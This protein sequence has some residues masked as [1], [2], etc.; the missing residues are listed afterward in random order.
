MPAALAALVLASAQAGPAAAWLSRNGMTVREAGPQRIEVAFRP[1]RDDPDYWCAAGDF[2]RSALRLPGQTRIWRAS[3]KPR[4]AGEGILF[5]LDAA[6][7]A[8][9]AGLSQFGAGP[10]DGSISVAMAVGS[11]CSLEIP[12]RPD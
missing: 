2:A 4:G 1:G 8:E 5:T 3:P 9:G 10:R 12:L 11:H 6:Q 7:K